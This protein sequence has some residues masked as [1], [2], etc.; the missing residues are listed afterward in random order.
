MRI[1]ISPSLTKELAKIKKK[2]PILDKRIKKQLKLFATNPK[3]Q[4]LR[5]HKLSSNLV[6]MWSISITKSIRMCYLLINGDEAYF[7]D[8][9]DHSKVYGKK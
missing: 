9:G 3:H 8:V 1:T 7:Y 4:S 5:V 6:N 2:D